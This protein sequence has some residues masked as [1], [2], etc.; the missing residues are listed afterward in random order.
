ME[1]QVL[2]PAVSGKDERG[3]KK[4]MKTMSKAL[5]LNEKG[6]F[7]FLIHQI[8]RYLFLGNSQTADK[9]DHGDP[10]RGAEVF[11]GKIPARPL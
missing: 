9:S 2:N 3:A 6:L 8:M 5:S 1:R 4:T 7:L 11:A 10:K